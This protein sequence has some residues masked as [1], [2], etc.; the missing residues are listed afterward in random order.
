MLPQA[1]HWVVSCCG[2]DDPSSTR[3]VREPLT[4]TARPAL[5]AISL[6]RLVISSVCSCCG[7]FTRS[8]DQLGKGPRGRHREAAASG[9]EPREP[10]GAA[11]AGDS[12]SGVHA[13]VGAAPRGGNR[14][15]HLVRPKGGEFL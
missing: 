13:V 1:A 8:I 5:L 14:S 7:W 6:I 12:E 10:P 2:S 3:M 4:Q 15:R 9:D 11:A